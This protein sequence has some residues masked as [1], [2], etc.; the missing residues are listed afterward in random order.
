MYL[1]LC[2]KGIQAQF[3]QVLWLVV[4]HKAAVVISR[5]NPGRIYL[6]SCG[7]QQTPASGCYIA[8]YIISLPQGSLYKA[9]PEM[10]AGFPQSEGGKAPKIGATAFL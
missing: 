2:R 4:S 1:C 5:L 10:A 9:A 3:N 8:G 7:W 6:H